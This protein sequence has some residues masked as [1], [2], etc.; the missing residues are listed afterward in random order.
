[1]R[2]ADGL[3]PYAQ[4]APVILRPGSSDLH[5]REHPTSLARDRASPRS[6][7]Q[8][9]GARRDDMSGHTVAA[10]TRLGNCEHPNDFTSMRCLQLPK[11]G[12]RALRR[13]SRIVQRPGRD[14][15]P[16]LQVASCHRDT[17]RHSLRATELPT[18]ARRKRMQLSPAKAAPEN[19][20]VAHA[21]AQRGVTGASQK[22][23]PG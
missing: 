6:H 3:L 22:R 18:P 2:C 23:V 13:L 5:V 19:R 4:Q 9:T 7:E 20:A 21:P 15:S 11:Y 1:M 14:A 12:Q 16:V 17:S 8:R 10:P